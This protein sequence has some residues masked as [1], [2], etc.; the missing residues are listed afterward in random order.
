MPGEV[1]DQV[2]EKKVMLLEYKHDELRD[3]VKTMAEQ[4]SSIVESNRA[5]SESLGKLTVIEERHSETR[6]D[7]SDIRSIMK[8]MAE[9]FHALHRAV[10]DDLDKR[11]KAIE[12]VLPMLIE[13]RGWAIKILLS[14]TTVV[15]AAIMGIVFGGHSPL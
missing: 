3:V 11:L 1:C 12:H 2:L 6:N 14:V 10:P 4:Q 8:D 7:I 15:G 13:A 5:I 9:K